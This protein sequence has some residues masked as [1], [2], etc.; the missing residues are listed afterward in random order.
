MNFI[1]IL[2]SNFRSFDGYEDVEETFQ[3]LECVNREVV[4]SNF[5]KNSLGDGKFS[6]RG[7]KHFLLGK[8]FKGMNG[9]KSFSVK[10]LPTE[11]C[12][13]RD[14]FLNDENIPN[15]YS[16]LYKYSLKMGS[17]ILKF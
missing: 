15:S 12:F 2:N 1:P 3:I 17:R 6:V 14:F 8:F 13:M 5:F 9:K 10:K 4:R 7:W 11:N 16:N